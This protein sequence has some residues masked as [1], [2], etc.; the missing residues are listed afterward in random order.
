VA[1]T[2]TGDLHV[3]HEDGKLNITLAGMS[4]E[5]VTVELVGKVLQIRGPVAEG[6]AR[7]NRRFKLHSKVV[8]PNDITGAPRGS[9][10]P[11]CERKWRGDSKPMRRWP[12]T[13]R[14]A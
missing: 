12:A 3:K 13:R 4:K 10:A 11:G 7:I 2:S 6:S 14:A 1:P 9:R 8:K 5:G